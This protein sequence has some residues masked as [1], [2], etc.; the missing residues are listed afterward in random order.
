MLK[1]TF[2]HIPGIGVKT[3]ERLWDSGVIDWDGFREPYPVELSQDRAVHLKRY[4]RESSVHFETRNPNYFENLLPSNLH[5]RMFPEFRDSTVYLDI[6]TTGLKM[7]G[8]E[9]TTISL[10]DGESISYYVKDQN[11]KDFMDDIQ[12]YRVIVTYNGKTFDIPF[13]QSHFGINLTH[14]HIDLRYILASLGFRGGLKGCEK[15]LGIDRGDLEDI[16]GYF[17]VLLWYDYKQNN[18]PK[19]LETLL[20]YNIQDTVNLETLMVLAYNIKL[21]DTPF[22]QTHQLPM[23]L[24]PAIPYKADLRTIDRIR[25]RIFGGSVMY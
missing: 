20:A 5:W 17:A 1:N 8:F 22:F 18:N 14:A 10:Y 3:E 6:E 11:L 15:Q 13:I 24:Q 12:K 16:D 9:I 21:K 4:I 23:P 2:I 19:A 7:W 25:R